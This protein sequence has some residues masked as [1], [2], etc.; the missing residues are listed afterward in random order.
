MILLVPVFGDGVAFE[1]FLFRGRK[2]W[3]D[4]ISVM[5]PCLCDSSMKRHE[6]GKEAA[7][8]CNPGQPMKASKIMGKKMRI[9]YKISLVHMEEVNEGA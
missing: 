1:K 7:A 9:R 4:P 6:E 5:Y 8:L 3:E 2:P